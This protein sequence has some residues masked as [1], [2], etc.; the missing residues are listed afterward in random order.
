[1]S[2]QQTFIFADLAGFTALTEA[3]G[4]EHAADLAGEF[5]ARTRP[6]LAEHS[7][8][9]VKLIGDALMLRSE[10]PPAAIRLACRIVGEIG[11]RH[12][13]PAV[14][15][16][17]HTGEA[18]ARGNDWYGST[19]NL[20]ARVAASA[21]AGEVLVTE[22]AMRAAAGGVSDCWFHPVGP[23]HFKNVREPTTLFTVSSS[24][25]PAHADRTLA[26]DPVCLMAVD[27]AAGGHQRE[28][29]GRPFVLCSQACAEAFDGDPHRFAGVTEA[30]QLTAS[31]RSRDAAVTFLRNAHERGLLN[32]GELEERLARA[33][34]ART[35]RQLASATSLRRARRRQP[36]RRRR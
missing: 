11:G 24:A 10:S 26:I 6:L 28:S 16:G 19:V 8:H 29:G 12:A 5:A 36:R 32:T 31:G 20:A 1:M 15:A 7:A 35:P 22:A 18:V 34:F 23:R 14:R 27:P 30:S 17:L 25:A 2:G 4:D 3:H 33:I 21:A 13:F 9:Q